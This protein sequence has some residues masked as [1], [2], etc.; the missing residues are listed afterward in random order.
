VSEPQRANHGIL[1]VASTRQVR[2]YVRV[3]AREHKREVAVAV[4]LHTG[5]ALAGVGLPW[6]VGRLVQSVADGTTVATVD[7]V[8]LSMVGFVVAQ[9]LLTRF[10]RLASAK[11]GERV[12]ARLLRRS[13]PRAAT[14]DCGACR[15]R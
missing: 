12:L 4:A 2:R 1:P 3:L 10:A 7:R 14:V 13:H 9:A 11:L 6:L 5:G 8:V 15:Y